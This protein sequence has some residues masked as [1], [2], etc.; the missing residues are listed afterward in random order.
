MSRIALFHSVLGVRPGIQDAADR[1]RAA[2]HQVTVVDQYD[3]RHFNDYDAATGYADELGYPE[4]MGR[5]QEAV[6]AL[7]DGFVAA[8]FSNGGGMAEFI[9]TQRRVSGVLMLSGA[10]PLELL[11]GDAWPVGVP[12]Q[13]HYML[14]DPFRRQEWI[15]GVA[16]S[17]R[18]AG[19]EVD[20]FDYDGEGHLFTD[21]SL[22]GEYQADAAGLLWQR[23]LAFAPLSARAA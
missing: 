15:E 4:L 16:E 22:P 19:A 5:A 12:A 10:M 8:G 23:V 18:E 7:P 9:A 13:I 17:V 2:G 21:P 6:E 14:R 20:V 3:G 1:L 11:G